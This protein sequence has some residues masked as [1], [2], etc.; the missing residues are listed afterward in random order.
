[1]LPEPLKLSAEHDAH[2]WMTIT[3]AGARADN[4]PRLVGSVAVAGA[5]SD[6]R[7]SVGRNAI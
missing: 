1:M 3:D 2:E 6:H 4:D 7:N 5:V